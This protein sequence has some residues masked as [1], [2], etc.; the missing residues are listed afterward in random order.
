MRLFHG[1][2]SA[3]EKYYAVGRIVKAVGKVSYSQPERAAAAKLRI[4]FTGE[5]VSR[6]RNLVSAAFR[7]RCIAF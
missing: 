1:W 3:G 6:A 2:T 4:Y 5:T 7:G